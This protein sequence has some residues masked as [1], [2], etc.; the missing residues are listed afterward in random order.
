MNA[1]GLF[2]RQPEAGLRPPLSGL[3]G[4][5]FEGP[6]CHQAQQQ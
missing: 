4:N 1:G 5:P 3:P 6:R 2:D